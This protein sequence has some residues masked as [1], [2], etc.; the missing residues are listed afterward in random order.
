MSQNIVNNGERV[1]VSFPF[2]SGNAGMSRRDGSREA[3]LAIREK[4]RGAEPGPG[5]VAGQPAKAVRI[6]RSPTVEGMT[7][8]D[9]AFD[10]PEPDQD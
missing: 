5:A 10:D 6:Q 7:L 9:I 1:A 2:Y 4:V 3:T 8:V